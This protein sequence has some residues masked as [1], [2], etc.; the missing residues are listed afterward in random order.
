MVLSANRD[1]SACES[2]TGDGWWDLDNNDK[3]MTDNVVRHL[4]SAGRVTEVL[5]L[6]TDYR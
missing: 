3:Y 5:G 1:G 6:L 4:L 2:T